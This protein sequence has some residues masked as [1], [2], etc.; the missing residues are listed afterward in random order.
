MILTEKLTIKWSPASKNHFEKIGYKFTKFG[1]EIVVNCEELPQN[2]HK[3]VKVKCDQC[4]KEKEIEYRYY[5]NNITING[6]NS[7]LCPKC[8]ANR[9]DM[10]KEKT[11]KA[12]LTNLQRY[13]AKNP[14]EIKEFQEKMK[15]TCLEK[16]GQE[17]YIQSDEGKQ[18]IKNTML[19]KYGVEKPLEVP[20]FLEKSKQ[21]CQSHYG[22]DFSLQ[23]K[24]VRQKI[25]ETN[26]QRY[27]TEIPLKN[28]EIK[29]KSEN[30]TFQHFG[31]TCSLSSEEVREKGKNTMMK[32]Y[33]V[34]NPAQSPEI[35]S[36]IRKTF[37][38]SGKTRTSKQQ[39]HIFNVLNKKY[40][41]VDLNYP[42]RKYSLDCF[43]VVDSVKIDVEY[44]GWYWHQFLKEEDKVRDQFVN[45]NDIRVVRLK[46]G[47]TI[48]S[49]E[50]IIELIEKVIKENLW[51]IE[52]IYPEWEENFNKGEKDC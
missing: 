17:Y 36:K 24:E 10:L 19:E 37:F 48:P 43:F 29:K 3:K 32:L 4:G 12:Q 14:G 18:K 20:E 31:V 30:T 13:R 51:F 41:Q 49:E 6:N 9:E 26:L 34:E 8:M 22:V 1:D 42:L 40:K 27:G 11:K 52:K 38:K 39:L 47:T 7:Y 35:Q 45:N 50:E 33:G 23:S 25:K 46:G 5:I 21:T 16:Y 15:K 28:E 2:S 44:D